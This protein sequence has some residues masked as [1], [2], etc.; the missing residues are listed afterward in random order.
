MQVIKQDVAQF[1]VFRAAQTKLER[2]KPLQKYFISLSSGSIITVFTRAV[3]L[4]LSTMAVR[5]L[6]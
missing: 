4:A 5:S 6:A 2:R 3:A 1:L